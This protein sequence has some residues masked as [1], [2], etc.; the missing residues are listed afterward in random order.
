MLPSGGDKFGRFGGAIALA[1]QNGRMSRNGHRDPGMLGSN[2]PR[3]RKHMESRRK[4]ISA[5]QLGPC[6]G[7]PLVC[8]VVGEAIFQ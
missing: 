7:V 5:Q 1:V 6:A 2:G 3:L 4:E 8:R